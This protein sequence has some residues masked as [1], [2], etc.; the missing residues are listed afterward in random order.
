MAIGNDINNI[1]RPN[2]GIENNDN[3]INLERE[4]KVSPRER[5]E[6]ENKKAEEKK[7]AE[8]R[9]EVREA[10]YGDVIGVSENG[11]TATAKEESVK[12]L[13][14]GMVFKKGP[15]NA[16]AQKAAADEKNVRDE[17][18]AAKPELQDIKLEKED[19]K[20]DSLT[21]YTKDQLQTLYSQGK[22]DKIKYDREIERRKELMQEDDQEKVAAR[23][24]DEKKTTEKADTVK[25]VKDE[26]DKE[27]ENKQDNS[28]KIRNTIESNEKAIETM[29]RVV[30]T[31]QDERL[32]ADA[33]QDALRNDRMDIMADIFNGNNNG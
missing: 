24:E 26:E 22:I 11:D 1:N 7:E 23:E 19:E 5:I 6:E 33:V 21:G 29:G 10:V 15:D 32:R 2:F 8:R 14:D 27:E 28:D 31:E 17:R 20:I 30:A 3:R 9:E 18:N 25:A 12:A 16:D 4:P 13:E